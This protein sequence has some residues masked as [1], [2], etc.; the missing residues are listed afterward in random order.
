[1]RPSSCWYCV[2]FCCFGRLVFA[3][4]T[5]PAFA[6]AANLELVNLTVDCSRHGEGKG[7]P[8]IES[9]GEAIRLVNCRIEQRQSLSVFPDD[10]TLIEAAAGS[11]TVIQGCELY[12]LQSVIW[13]VQ[14]EAKLFIDNSLILSPG[15]TYSATSEEGEGEVTVNQSSCLHQVG[16]THLVSEDEAPA[17]RFSFQNSI[18]DC[19]QFLVWLPLGNE[20]TLRKSLTYE[21]NQVLFLYH[22]SS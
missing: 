11:E 6:N 18:I 12:T 17:V 19:G 22:L 16:V 4:L 9:H 3:N 7:W 14:K 15:L 8:L 20:E 2:V 13:R 5:G 10:W 21:A 1:M